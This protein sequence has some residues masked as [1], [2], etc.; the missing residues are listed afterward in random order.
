MFRNIQ[1][2]N[3]Q[4]T[5]RHGAGII[6]GLPE[7]QITNVVLENVDISAATKGLTIKNAKAVQL[8]NVQVTCKEGLPVIV[9][10]AQVE[11]LE[12]AKAAGG[13]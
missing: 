11:G 12:T 1:I 7:S 10:N 13:K 2:K 4:A 6:L 5:T 3:L 8:K 9:E